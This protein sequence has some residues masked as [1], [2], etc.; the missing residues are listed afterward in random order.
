MF[1]GLKCLV[2]AQ[3]FSTE[4]SLMLCVSL[5]HLLYVTLAVPRVSGMHFIMLQDYVLTWTGGL[6][7]QLGAC[8]GDYFWSRPKYSSCSDFNGGCRYSYCQGQSTRTVSLNHFYIQ[9]NLH[10]VVTLLV[11]NIL[12]N[13]SFICC[14]VKHS[15]ICCSLRQLWLRELNR[16][17]SGHKIAYIFVEKLVYTEGSHNRSYRGIWGLC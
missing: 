6:G 13:L 2:L 4:C 8:K 14:P 15:L 5:N 12:F 3:S 16:Q 7:G 10:D 1:S 9:M 17:P 11:D